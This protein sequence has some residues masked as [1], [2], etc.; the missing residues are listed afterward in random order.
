M[1]HRN[2]NGFTIVE[3]LVGLLIIVL[4]ITIV[5][6][7]AATSRCSA[8]RLQSA[9]NLRRLHIA[10]VSYATDWNRSQWDSIPGDYNEYSSCQDYIDQVGCISPL[11]LGEDCDEAM[12]AYWIPCPDTGGFG[13]CINAQVSLPISIQQSLFGSFRFPNNKAIHDYVGGRFYDPT[14][15][16]PGDQ[17]YEEASDKFGIDCGYVPDNNSITFSSYCLSPAA[18]LNPIAMTP[19]GFDQPDVYQSPSVDQ[20][21]YPSQK[22]WLMEHNWIES[23]EPCN[24][25]FSG[26][27][28][29]FY[30][31]ST[32]STPYTLFF[33]GHVR[34]LTPM[35]S[36][37]SDKRVR[38]GG[39]EGLWSRDTPFGDSGY[40]GDVSFEFFTE[41]SY[42]VFTFEGILGRD[43][44]K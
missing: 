7:V 41:T 20:A 6:P 11:T 26:C 18:M 17:A 30:N 38:A 39:G 42:H 28:P 43:T 32:Q 2:R 44:V 24:P 40:Y 37:I 8:D 19:G 25:A 27:V 3:L 29:F 31:A 33:D 10:L 15:Y 22:T 12:W 1:T 34:V 21:K 13:S 4:L 23:P 16:A 9:A 36:M 35:E 14:F 5:V